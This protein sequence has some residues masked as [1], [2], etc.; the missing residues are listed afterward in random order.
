MAQEEARRMSVIELETVISDKQLIVSGLNDEIL[1]RNA[2]IT[3]VNNEITALKDKVI[4]LSAK[5]NEVEIAIGAVSR[6]LAELSDRKVPLQ[7]EIVNLKEN[8]DIASK[9]YAEF[10]AQNESIMTRKEQELKQLNAKLLAAKQEESLIR[11]VVQSE[12]SQLASR[13]LA[14]DERDKILRIREQKAQIQEN[15]IHQNASLLE[16]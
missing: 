3:S 1:S 8:K 4:E 13:K 12:S 15:I 9:E 5:K 6:Q 14:L 2:D 16:L 10:S 11:K 7:E